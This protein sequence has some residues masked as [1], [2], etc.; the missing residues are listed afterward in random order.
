MR[1]EIDRK[2][3]VIVI[4]D[5]VKMKDLIEELESLIGDD[6]ENYD[7]ISKI[8][9]VPYQTIPWYNPGI[10]PYNPNPSFPEIPINPNF[11][12]YPIVYC[13][14]TGCKS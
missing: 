13:N 4:S 11:P 1:L 14:A 6:Y 3:K 10:T 8:Q 5:P 12:T 2:N 7:I 9:C